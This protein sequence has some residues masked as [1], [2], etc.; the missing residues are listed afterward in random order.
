MPH[1]TTST[2]DNLIQGSML[3]GTKDHSFELKKKRTIKNSFDVCSTI[4]KSRANKRNPDNCVGK[5]F[6]YVDTEKL[7]EKAD[8]FETF[9]AAA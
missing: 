1:E 6:S 8:L 5:P 7:R 4:R 9:S 3:G 2:S